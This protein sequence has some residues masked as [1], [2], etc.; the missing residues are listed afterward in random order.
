MHFST[1]DTS[2]GTSNSTLKNHTEFLNARIWIIQDIV[3]SKN[4]VIFDGGDGIPWSQLSQAL[5]AWLLFSPKSV[6]QSPAIMFVL[7]TESIRLKYHG[8]YGT[9]ITLPDILLALRSCQ[10]LA[11]DPKDY[12]YVAYSIARELRPEGHLYEIDYNSSVNET[13]A[14][15]SL[16]L[17]RL[18]NQPLSLSL[19]DGFLLDLPSW[20]PDWETRSRR[21]LFNHPGSS[22]S[23]SNYTDPKGFSVNLNP[24]LEKILIC[25]GF[26]VES[27]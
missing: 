7:L 26:V 9:P 20:T 17:N 23:A 16:N 12:T 25:T 11:A 13:Y 19:V 27:R 22:F 6:L 5:L 1:T 18:S 3:C 24:D 2:V 15:A 10:V 4:L 14:R 8:L 21:L